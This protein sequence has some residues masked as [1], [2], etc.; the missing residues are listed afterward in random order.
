MNRRYNNNSHV[1]SKTL[2]PLVL[3]WIESFMKAVRLLISF[4]SYESYQKER[5]DRL[6]IP[7]PILL[8]ISLTHVFAKNM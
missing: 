6:N 7:E 8:T 2:A 1:E 4:V 5:G 3:L